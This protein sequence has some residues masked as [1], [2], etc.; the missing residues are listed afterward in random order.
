MDADWFSKVSK[1][2]LGVYPGV[3]GGDMTELRLGE[4]DARVECGLRR[5]RPS[6]GT[7]EG[8]TEGNVRAEV[9]VMVMGR[10][11]GEELGLLTRESVTKGDWGKAT[12]GGDASG[13][14]EDKRGEGEREI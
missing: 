2:T 8:R 6:P 12:L 11:V 13:G 1:E 5:P 9:E 10:E 3:R 7:G 14:E 4:L